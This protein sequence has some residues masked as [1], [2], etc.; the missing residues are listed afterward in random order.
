MKRK[1]PLLLCV[2]ALALSTTVQA[3]S[4]QA[5]Q[6]ETESPFVRVRSYQNA[7]ADVKS[8]SWYAGSVAALYEY[9]LA[10]GVG[11]DAYAPDDAVTVAQLATFSARI[12]AAYQGDTIPAAQ[13]GEAW[14]QPYVRYLKAEGVL[15]NEYDGHYT[16]KATRAQMAGIFAPTLPDEWYDG[17][18]ADAVTQGYALRQFI[19]DVDDYTPY[20]QEILWLYKQGILDGAD[21]TGAFLPERTVKRSEIAAL[22]TRM[23]DPS[24]R[25]ALDW[26]PVLYTSARGMTYADLVSDPGKVSKAPTSGDSTAIDALIRKML[27]DETN[28]IALEYGS[29][30]SSEEV[31]KL[32]RAFTTGVKRYCE[33]MYNSTTCRAYATGKVYLTFSSTVCDDAQLQEYRKTAMTRAIEIHDELWESGYLTENMN[34]YELARA[35]YRWLCDHCVYDNAAVGNTSVSHLAYGALVDGV[36][37]C[38]GYTGAYNL[39]LRLEGIECTALFNDEHIWTVATL[40]GTSYHIDTTWGDRDG[41]V[42]MS[43]FG[44]T[45]QESR[46]KHAW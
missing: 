16:D 34:Q 6:E 45:E 32:T 27:R 28:T 29:G 20:Q 7:F 11:G 2:L 24:L 46:A 9:G 44:M 37:V 31:G 35:Y 33:Q 1:F 18:N 26:Q 23:I 22:V 41:Q 30:L 40:D 3:R 42:D 13:T 12:R 4:V 14:Y 5:A 43:F 10:D 19:K 21:K 17:R 36:A 39:L 8:T 25:L 38:D 15:G